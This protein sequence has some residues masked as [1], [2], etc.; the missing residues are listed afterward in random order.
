MAVLRQKS[1][2]SLACRRVHSEGCDSFL[3]L[4]DL[5]LAPN[6]TNKGVKTK[7]PVSLYIV[8]YCHLFNN[9]IQTM[10]M[11]IYWCLA[12][13]WARK[14]ESGC[15]GL[16]SCLTLSTFWWAQKFDYQKLRGRLSKYFIN[17]SSLDAKF[18]SPNH[19]K[20]TIDSDRPVLA[21]DGRPRQDWA[22]G[23]RPGQGWAGGGRSVKVWAGDPR[24]RQSWIGGDWSPAAGRQPGQSWTDSDRSG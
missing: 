8:T 24:P 17:G 12:D 15:G 3:K 18:M 2:F 10:Y 21:Y 23:G 19:L 13:G 20:I 5:A 11:H 22:G 6:K 7:H 14:G 4:L 9:G 16:D 1:R